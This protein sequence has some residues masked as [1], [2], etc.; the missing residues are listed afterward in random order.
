MEQRDCV[1][2]KEIRKE[3]GWPILESAL[4]QQWKW[5]GHIARTKNSRWSGGITQ[6][7]NL[8][9]EKEQKG[10]EKGAGGRKVI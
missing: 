2:C 3:Q 8:D 1:P 7:S 6:S 9:W 5:A 10:P 4:S